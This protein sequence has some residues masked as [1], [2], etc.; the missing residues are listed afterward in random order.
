MKAHKYAELLI[1]P[2]A[3][4]LVCNLIRKKEVANLDSVFFSNDSVGHRIKEISIAIA[5]KMT[6]EV[7]SSKFG[8]AVQVD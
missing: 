3:K 4:I 6:A 1:M 7:R 5:Y 2:A 8:F